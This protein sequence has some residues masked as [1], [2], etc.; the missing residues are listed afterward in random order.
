NNMSVGELWLRLLR[1]YSLEFDAPN[2]VVSIRSNQE[3]PRTTKPWNNKKL[4]VEDPYMLKKNVTRTVGNSHLYE[5]WQDSIRRALRYFGLPRTSAEKIFIPV[6]EHKKVA[7]KRT[8]QRLELR[9]QD[10][11]SS[12]GSCVHDSRVKIVDSVNAE[13]VDSNKRDSP[14]KKEKPI[15]KDCNSPVVIAPNPL[16]LG[17]VIHPSKGP[18]LMCTFCDKEG[19][20][21]NDCPDN[22]LPEVDTLPPLTPFHITVLSETLSKVPAEVGLSGERLVEREVFMRGLEEFIQVQFTDAKLSL[23]GSSCN[24]FGFDKSD[25]DI[26]LTFTQRKIGD[27]VMVIESLARKMKQHLDLT[28]VQAIPTAK[29]PIVKFTVK[30]TGLEG[31][32]SLYNT[33]AEQNTKLLLCYN[34]IDP[35]VN[36][37]GYAI[38]TFAKVCD[39][40]DASRGSLSSYAYILMMLYYL[41]QVEPPVIPVLQ[42]LY[43]GDK[44]PQRLVEGWDAWFQDDLSLLD[45][46]WPEKGKN[47]M[48]VAELWLGFLCFYV[49][50]FKYKEHVVS[51]RQ[52]KPLTRFE[53]L[54]NGPCIAIEDPFDL[55]HNLGSALTRTMNNF[56]FKTFINGR[57]LYGSPI[58]E[59]MDMFNKYQRPSDYFF[60]TDLLSES[61]PPNVRGCRRCGKVGHLVRHC[62]AILK[63]KEDE[64]KRLQQ[65]LQQQKQ[66][67]QQKQVQQ[68][69]T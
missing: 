28:N 6:Q 32:I 24:G 1:Y 58:D 9:E 22:N 64:Q 55:S 61:R 43:R 39:I 41:Q 20:L 46:L 59:N 50:E 57:M 47:S 26:C 14:D 62:P 35:R 3:I 44:K 48:S 36:T 40:G 31:D 66:Q 49:E 69:W 19:H 15:E 21:K 60:D 29:V 67:Q 51:I 37:L 12:V 16:L 63:D 42:E 52:R 54:W 34:K 10:K 18:I 7:L 13:S 65:Q 17:R 11:E 4:A 45:E 56:I 2:T 23:F 8:S 53:K 33:L 68:E 5:Y 25:M 27:K 38:K 30:K